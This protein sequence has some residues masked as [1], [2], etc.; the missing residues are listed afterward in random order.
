MIGRVALDHDIPIFIFPLLGGFFGDRKQKLATMDA[1]VTES[2]NHLVFFYSD[3]GLVLVDRLREEKRAI[4][5]PLIAGI[6]EVDHYDVAQFHVVLV[7]S[8]E[9][10]NLFVIEC[11]DVGANTLH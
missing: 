2:G 9:E 5:D 4:E 6:L 11:G 7:L 1:F 8:P 10:D 3:G